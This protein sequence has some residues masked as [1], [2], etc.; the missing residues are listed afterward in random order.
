MDEALKETS[1]PA[2]DFSSPTT[3]PATFHGRGVQSQPMRAEVNDHRTNQMVHDHRYEPLPHRD[4]R[5][6]NYSYVMEN[7]PPRDEYVY[8]GE[9]RHYHPFPNGHRTSPVHYHMDHQHPFHDGKTNLN[10]IRK[11]FSTIVVPRFLPLNAATASHSSSSTRYQVQ[12]P[13]G[14]STYRWEN[15]RPS[16]YEY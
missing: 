1:D 8:G 9:N 10:K 14:D 15:G 6:P 7:S 16:R 5:M 3:L 11:C 2:F 13:S 12:E 4:E